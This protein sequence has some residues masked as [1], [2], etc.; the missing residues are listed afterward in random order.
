MVP[1]EI[2]DLD[3]LCNLV[4]KDDDFGAAFLEAGANLVPD[5]PNHVTLFQSDESYRNPQ[6]D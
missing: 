3:E 1:S 5:L 4:A 6:G 2:F